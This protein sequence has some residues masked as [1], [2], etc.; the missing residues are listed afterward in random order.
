MGASENAAT[1]RRWIDAY[2][3]RDLEAESAARAPG[4]LVH[5]P[6][7]P[8]PLDS[9]GW[10]AFAFGFAQAFP[11]LHLTIED[12]FATEDMVA[13]RVTFRGTHQGVFQ[14]IPA[15]GKQ[16]RFTSIE[17]NRMEGGKVAEHWVELDTLGLLR[18]IGAIPA[19]AAAAG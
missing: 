4:F 2:N 17:I 14:G 11:D 7:A 1:V 3:A 9:D 19:P 16:V 12:I 5:A 6:G 13:A 8:G 15:T 10:V 18:Q